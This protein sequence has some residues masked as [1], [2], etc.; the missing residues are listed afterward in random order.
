MPHL[1]LAQIETALAYYSSHKAEMDADIQRRFEW[2]EQMRLQEQSPLR[3]A[4]LRAR[5]KAR[6]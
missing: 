4:E 5:R 1:S 6:E 2:T 3:R